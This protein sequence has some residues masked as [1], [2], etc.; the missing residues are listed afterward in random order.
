VQYGNQNSAERL[1]L[2][3]SGEALPAFRQ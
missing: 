1:F 3:M 2:A